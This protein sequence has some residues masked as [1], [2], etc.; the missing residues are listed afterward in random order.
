MSYNFKTVGIYQSPPG[1]FPQSFR[2]FD[3]KRNY[4]NI[5]VDTSAIFC[6]NNLIEHCFKEDLRKL[7]NNKDFKNS[8][9]ILYENFYHL[10]NMSEDGYIVT[11][12]Q[13][14]AE[15]PVTRDVKRNLS[16][17]SK[18]F[19]NQDLSDTFMDII[20]LRK[21]LFWNLEQN[22]I[23]TDNF[24]FKSLKGKFL[25]SD[26]FR[27][28]NFGYDSKP[29][30]DEDVDLYV[31]ALLMNNTIGKCAIFTKDSDFMN[32]GR[33]KR[34]KVSNK[35]K[36]EKKLVPG[37]YLCPDILKARIGKYDV[38]KHFLRASIP[39]VMVKPCDVGS[40]LYF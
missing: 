28:I 22:L 32:Q 17:I 9:N 29:I 7:H 19:H 23:D 10:A 2:N 37:H 40:D 39:P 30:S 11:I 12:P 35:E 25:N 26:G 18:Y 24:E 6:L 8:V 20:K 5:L 31:Q 1:T 13:I 33:C 16:S 27:P 36:L 15:F 38:I 4:N 34:Y 14:F 3:I 21:R